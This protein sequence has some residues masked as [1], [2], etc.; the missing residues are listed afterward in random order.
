VRSR[1]ATLSSYLQSSLVSARIGLRFLPTLTCNYPLVWHTH[2]HTHTH[3]EW[4]AKYRFCVFLSYSFK[5]QLDLTFWIQWRPTS[6]EFN[7]LFISA[8]AET[9]IALDHLIMLLF[10]SCSLLQHLADMY[11]CCRQCFFN[12]LWN[13][14]TWTCEFDD[15]VLRPYDH[16]INPRPSADKAK[17]WLPEWIH[18][19]WTR[20]SWDMRV[21]C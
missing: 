14:R 15:S 13:R 11:G 8:K 2:T 7:L 19:C 5:Y 20:A 18:Q 9:I 1:S 6:Q 3:T 17:M 12:S 21:M 16:E 10:M 4:W